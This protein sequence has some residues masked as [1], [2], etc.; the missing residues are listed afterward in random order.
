MEKA[1]ILEMT[2][3][4]LQ[5]RCLSKRNS[6]SPELAEARLVTQLSTPYQPHSR[7]HHCIQTTG[8]S[9]LPG[10]TPIRPALSTQHNG[11]PNAYMDS[12]IPLYVDATPRLTNRSMT[13]SPTGSHCSD[14]SPNSSPGGSTT[15]SPPSLQP[16]RPASEPRQPLLYY[17][18]SPTPQPLP[19]AWRPW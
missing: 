8:L 6:R 1:D 16:H 5:S 7:P 11:Q 9:Q 19:S 3:S 14:E 12:A 2:V 13:R 15:C 17:H 18:S 4:Y 10:T